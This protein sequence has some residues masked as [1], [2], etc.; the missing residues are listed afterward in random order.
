MLLSLMA[1]YGAAEGKGGESCF[2]RL[3]N[4]RVWIRDIEPY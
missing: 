3:P 4:Q 1:S 2:W